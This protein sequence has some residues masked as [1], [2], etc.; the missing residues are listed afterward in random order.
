MNLLSNLSRVEAPFI[1][2]TIGNYTFGMYSKNNNN[3]NSLNTLKKD[4]IVY[5][6]FMKSLVINKTSGVINNY[7]L[8]MVYP[9]TQNDDPN[10]L[11]KAFSSVSQSREI[12]FSY[13]DFASPSFIFKEE[14]AII[15]DIKTNFDIR[16]SSISYTLTC[17]SSALKLNAG[18]FNFKKRI[19]KPSDV[20][21]ELIYNQ[22][23][24]LLEVFT[25]MRNKGLVLQNNLIASDDREVVIEAKKNISILNYLSYLVKCMTGQSNTNIQVINDTRYILNIVDDISGEYNGP[26][27][28]V[29]R[30]ETAISEAE[31]YDTYE[32]DVGAFS[33]DI[34]LDFSIEDD[35]TYSIL[36]NYSEDIK[37]SNYIYRINNQG[38]IESSYSPTIALSKTLLKTTEANKNWWTQVTQYPINASITLKGLLRPAVLMTYVKVNVLFYGRKHISSGTY[39]VTKQTD[40]IDSSGYRT[41]L[42]LTRIKG[43]TI[44]G[45]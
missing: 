3:S 26:Y 13:G 23:Y 20:I 28:K 7:I 4:T 12:L 29:S 40:T 27:L 22:R 31:S 45:Y 10:L 14:K 37:Q 2:V 6:N 8:S 21:K 9:V 43:D 44:S 19:A 16:N 36:Y 30:V 34:V 18:T 17:T 24:G 42:T 32:I 39:I 5:P 25:G 1:Y 35:Q 11:E 38:N 41:N 33:K 15:T